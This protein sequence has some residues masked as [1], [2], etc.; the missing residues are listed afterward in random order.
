MNVRVWARSLIAPRPSIFDLFVAGTLSIVLLRDKFHQGMF[1]VFYSVFILILTIVMKPKRNYISIPLFLIV[2]WSF[3]MIFV[4]N[5]IEIVPGNFMN[6]WLNVSIMFEGFIYILFGFFLLR[7]IIVYS[8]NLKFIF[9]LL[10][11]ALIPIMKVNAIG[12]RMTIPMAFILS[13]LIY[14]FLNRKIFWGLVIGIVSLTEVICLWPYIQTKFACRPYI[15]IEMLREI[16]S[17]PF[18]GS[19]FDHTLKPDNMTWV[20]KIG[21]MVYGWIY[22]H[23]DLLSIGAYLGVIV[24]ILLIWFIVESLFK[25]GKSGYLIPFLTILITSLFQLTFF[26]PVKATICL[27]LIGVCVKE[28]YKKGGLNEKV[29]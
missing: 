13:V 18:I 22:R 17:H 9:L 28:T 14:F 19:G 8:T 1:L 20:H 5:K 27:V 2:L 4:H 7:N 16:K 6:Y 21:N 12:G 24:T 3:F 10:P 11:I 26:E 25:I 15:W 23:N 29:T